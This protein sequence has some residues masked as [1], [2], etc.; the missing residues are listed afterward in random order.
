MSTK[1]SP[2]QA[3]RGHESRERNLTGGRLR[4]GLEN[5]ES[6]LQKKLPEGGT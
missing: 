2:D 6:L 3:G 5:N 4:R 1:R